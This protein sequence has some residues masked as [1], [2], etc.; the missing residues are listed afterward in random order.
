MCGRAPDV[1]R[2]PLFGGTALVG[3]TDP[4]PV[5]GLGHAATIDYRKAK[6]LAENCE[7]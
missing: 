5:P 2:L 4:S 1:G 6:R 3:P 7:I